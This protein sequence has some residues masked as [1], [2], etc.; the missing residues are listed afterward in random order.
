MFH[1]LPF[2]LLGVLLLDIALVWLGKNTNRLLNYI[3]EKE[4]KDYFLYYYIFY[5]VTM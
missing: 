5:N 1:G 4:I 2:L 3:L